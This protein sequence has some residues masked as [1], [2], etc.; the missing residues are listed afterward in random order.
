MRSLADAPSAYFSPLYPTCSVPAARLGPPPL[1]PSLL[2]ANPLPGWLP[3]GCASSSWSI[4]LPAA[5]PIC[6]SL[7]MCCPV[8]KPAELSYT[9]ILHSHHTP[10]TTRTAPVPHPYRT[11]DCALLHLLPQEVARHKVRV[12][13]ALRQLAT[14]CRLAAGWVANDQH[15]RCRCRHVCGWL[16]ST[17]G[18]QQLRLCVWCRGVSG[19]E[20]HE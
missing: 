4:I 13:V 19:V 18:L 10:K 12:R 14:H 16:T 3:E 1:C 5:A 2:D 15:H 20:G 6:L 11:C 8:V 17:L 7:L 9:L